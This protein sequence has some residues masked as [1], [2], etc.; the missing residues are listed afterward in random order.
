MNPAI[1]LPL[2]DNETLSTCT[3]AELIKNM[4]TDEDRVPRNVIDE[5]ARRGEQMLDVLA[6]IAQP[7]D[8]LESE[9]AGHWWLR[10]HAVM[11]LGLIP[12]E[13]AGMLLVDFIRK[14]CRDE[15]EN[16]QEWLS[17]HWPAL[18]HN[19][20][21][22]V[23]VSLREICADKNINWF[24]RT[25]MTDVVIAAAHNK[26][27]EELE[28]TLDW[29]G[30]FVAS[31]EECWEYRLSIANTLLDFPRER[32]RKL[33]TDLAARQSGLG[34]H[35]NMNDINKAYAKNKDQPDWERFNN[36]WCFYDQQKIENRQRRW[37]QEAQSYEQA[38]SYIDVASSSGMVDYLHETYQRD[39]PKIGRNDPCPCGS[40]KKYK[41]C[42]GVN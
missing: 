33:L 26:G 2:Y 20:P 39:T 8:K 23:I 10:L 7:D 31:E 22:P 35:F 12:G 27:A 25:N 9:I 15:D 29:A 21:A 16:L 13:L 36:P 30:G 4:I 41:K 19:K 37:Q 1:E 3:A 14:M 34:V 6:T 24:M 32:F 17:G 42:C 11:I 28:Q 38:D 18:M 40:G 5:C